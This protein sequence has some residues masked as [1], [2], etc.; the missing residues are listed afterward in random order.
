MSRVTLTSDEVFLAV[1][2]RPDAATIIRKVLDFDERIQ[3]KNEQIDDLRKELSGLREDQAWLRIQKLAIR[4]G[5][6]SEELTHLESERNSY[7]CSTLENEA[8]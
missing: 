3:S 5:F 8:T 2:H 1:R 7:I 4:A 6:L